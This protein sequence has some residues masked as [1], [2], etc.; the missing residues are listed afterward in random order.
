LVWCFQKCH[1]YL[2]LW[3]LW[4]MWEGG[5]QLSEYIEP[6][7]WGQTTRRQTKFS[8]SS[9]DH[10]HHGCASNQLRQQSQILQR[11]SAHTYLPDE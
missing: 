3:W 9:C 10:A 5:M 8:V 11:S 4:Q 2:W 7:A 6:A 1:G